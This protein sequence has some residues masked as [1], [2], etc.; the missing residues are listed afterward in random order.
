MKNSLVLLV[1]LCAYGSISAQFRLGVRSN[2]AISTTIT[3]S[4]ELASIEPIEVMNFEVTSA[5]K[6]LSYGLALYNSNDR[7]FF[8]TEA[9]YSKS[10]TNFRLENIVGSFQRGEA[11]KDFS[12]STTD[13]QIPVSAGVK[14]KNFKL[15]GGPIFNVRLDSE[16]TLNGVDAVTTKDRKFSSGF[17][18]LIG[19]E[20]LDHIH[21]DLKREI[22]FNRSGENYNYV[23]QPI[24][25]KSSPSFMSLS[26]G[27]F[28]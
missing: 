27:V 20:L 22:N 28:F 24:K 6:S 10:Q 7:L 11:V 14:I 15:G 2:V 17:A 19:Y 16:S 23:G 1:L 8:M 26:L 9:L 12:Y 4:K 18:F 3:D 5:Q 13:I 21:I 25:L